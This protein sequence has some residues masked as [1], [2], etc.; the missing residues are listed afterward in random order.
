VRV[1]HGEVLADPIRVHLSD[2]ILD[3]TSPELEALSDDTGSYAHV[4]LTVERSTVIGTVWT[5]AIDRA[6]DSIFLS[7]V[8]VARSQIGCMRFCYVP[9][10]SRTPRRYNCQPDR[11]MQV[12]EAELR[13]TAKEKKAPEPSRAE[14]DLA[15]QRESRRVHP[16]FNSLRYG[17]PTYCQ[18]AHSCAVE[19]KRGASDQSEMGAFHDLYQP[20]REANLRTRLEEYTPAGMNAGIIFAS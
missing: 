2:S 5:H 12:I 8:K 6:E 17:T 10:G 4:L 9:P 13:A 20:Q 15:Q 7:L 19:I 1:F 11:A 16:Q 18:L 14:I 3:A